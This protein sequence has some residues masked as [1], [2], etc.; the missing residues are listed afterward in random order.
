MA[1]LIFLGTGTSHGVPMIGCNCAVCTSSDPHNRRTRPSV[2]IQ[3][4]GR[5]IL[6]DAAPE[7]RIQLLRERIAFADALLFTHYHADHLFGLD[8]VRTFPRHLQHP[9]PIYCEPVVERVIRRAFAYA[10]DR[11]SRHIPAGGVPQLEFRSIQAGRSFQAA[12]VNC[13]P[14][15][16]LHGPFRVLGFRVGGLA[17]CTDVNRIP[18]RS[19][20]RLRGLDVLVLDAL[21]VRPHPTHFSVAESLE[22]VEQ[23]K[24]SR[25]YF[26]HIAHELDHGATNA[27]L[28][29]H[30]RL[31]FDGLSIEFDL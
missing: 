6:I 31:A 4:N 27:Q 24:P 7:L 1:R 2:V 12:G 5:T 20:P 28:P 16:L 15:R 29:S 22:V 11:R 10:F 13:L 17:Y 23:L 30:V 18:R 3:S 8:D 14:I 9:L 26:T 21:R 19:L 25:A